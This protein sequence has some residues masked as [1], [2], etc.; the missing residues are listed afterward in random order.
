MHCAD[1]TINWGKSDRTPKHERFHLGF[2][3]GL[4]AGLFKVPIARWETLRS[5]AYAI[6]NSKGTRVQARKLAS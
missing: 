4:D 2:D 6:L 3:V 5:D 1:L